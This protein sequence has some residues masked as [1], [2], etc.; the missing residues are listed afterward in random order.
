MLMTD[1]IKGLL[2][3]IEEKHADWQKRDFIKAEIFL[4]LGVNYIKPFSLPL[5]SDKN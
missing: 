1:I 3:L 5:M 4:H 2:F